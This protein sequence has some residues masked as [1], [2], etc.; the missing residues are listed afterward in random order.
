MPAKVFKFSRE[1]VVFHEYF[2]RNVGKYIQNNFN[3]KTNLFLKQK[4]NTMRT[5]IKYVVSI[6]RLVSVLRI[7]GKHDLNRAE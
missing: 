1:F 7:V 4:G 2:S 6:S 5:I 3:K